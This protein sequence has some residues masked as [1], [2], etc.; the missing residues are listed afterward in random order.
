ME[1]C[2][3]RLHTHNT[4]V[5]L[6]SGS[7]ALNAGT[8]LG[9]HQPLGRLNFGFTESP[10]VFGAHVRPYSQVGGLLQGLKASSKQSGFE[11]VLLQILLPGIGV[12]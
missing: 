2:C 12:L 9:F 7:P 10:S 5:T 1:P 11:S 4:H 3:T 6:H 8:Y